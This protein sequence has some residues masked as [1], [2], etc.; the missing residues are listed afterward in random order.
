M[1]PVSPLGL[2]AW[3][4]NRTANV[5]WAIIFDVK[6]GNFGDYQGFVLVTNLQTTKFNMAALEILR[7]LHSNHPNPVDGKEIYERTA[8]L[9]EIWDHIE[10]AENPIQE[11]FD[12][13]KVC[14]NTLSMGRRPQ[15]A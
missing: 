9:K 5:W 2:F 8:E 1:A 15:L 12:Y 14:E 10:G 13:L 11:Y 7:H 6:Q 4:K 3:A